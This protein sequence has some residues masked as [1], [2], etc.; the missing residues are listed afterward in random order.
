MDAKALE[1]QKK[2]VVRASTRIYYDI[3]Y[4]YFHYISI[5]I[6]SHIPLYITS[7]INNIFFSRTASCCA[8]KLLFLHRQHFVELQCSSLFS[9]AECNAELR[10]KSSAVRAPGRKISGRPSRPISSAVP[11]N[12]RARKEVLWAGELRF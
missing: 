9:A 8:E 7:Y 2:L 6:I 3:T 12:F 11:H 10:T 1:G 4:I 5:Y